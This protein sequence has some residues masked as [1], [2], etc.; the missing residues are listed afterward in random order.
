MLNDIYN[1]KILE[2]AGN[3][4]HLGRLEHPQGSAKAHSRLCGSTVSVDVR[5]EKDRVVAF[6]QDVKAC[7]LGQASAS[8][9]GRHV[10]GASKGE[11]VQARDQ[12]RA[13]LKENGP[14]PTNRFSELEFL[15]PVKDYKARHA[16]TML[17]FNAVVE[18]IEN[19][20]ADAGVDD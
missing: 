15:S 8:I 9:L 6:A 1:Q 5:M 20:E 10:I 4:P 3:V 17:A 11:L 19:A 18:A 14:P 7:A 2:F 16:S 13:M 12:L